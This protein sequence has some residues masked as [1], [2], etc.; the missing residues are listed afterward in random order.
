MKLKRIAAL[1]MASCLTISLLGC[2]KSSGDNGSAEISDGAP[3]LQE[4]YQAN[5][6]EAYEAANIQPSFSVCLREG[7]EKEETNALLT[8]YWDED[9]GLVSR[10]RQKTM[11]FSYYFNKDGTDYAA[12]I[13]ENEKVTLKVLV[14]K[15]ADTEENSVSRAEELFNQYGFGE[16]NSKETIVSCT[17]NGDTYHIITDISSASFTDSSGCTYTYT[18]QEYDVEKETLRILDVFRTY[19]FKDADGA[20]KTCTRSRCMT[21]G[22]SLH[23]LPDFMLNNF[24]KA[25]WTREFTLEY[26]DGSDESILVPDGVE[27]LIDAPSGYQAYMDSEHETVYDADEKDE[28]GIYPDRII[29]IAK[30]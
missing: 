2:G 8:L 18:T 28:D 30:K 7:E 19:K 22:K 27:V 23:L 4:I 10:F 20:E 3:S 29:Y 6:L 1:A 15:T 5:T 21:Y 12:S 14:G 13:D 11:I 24:C 26:P 25:E 16:Y 9:L 17:D